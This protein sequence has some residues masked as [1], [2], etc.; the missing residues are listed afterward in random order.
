MNNIQHIIF[1]WDGTL[2]MTLHLWLTGFRDSLQKQ[3][4]TF[5]DSIIA[6]EFFHEHE[7]IKDKY[8]SLDF[9][10]LYDDTRDHVFR[11]MHDLE[12]YPGALQT[13]QTLKG[14]GYTL[15]LVS[16]SVRTLLEKGLELHNCAQYFESI[17]SGDD[18][19]KRKPDPMAFLQTLERT[20]TLPEETVIIG[21][22]RTDIVA[23]KAA[24]TKTI[25]FAPPE[26]E[27]FYDMTVAHK[28]NPDMTI[29][30]L[31]ECRKLLP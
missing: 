3:D 27:L 18:V 8:T 23:G 5:P 12:L 21:D 4:H 9:E 11:H 17:I 19:T 24:K 14:S 10:K 15:S 20:G 31:S 16:S 28:E 25:L 2:A 7:L 13:L 29:F 22:A 26:N 1:D 6:E 30:A